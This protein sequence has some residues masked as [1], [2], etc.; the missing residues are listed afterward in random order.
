M[1]EDMIRQQT[2]KPGWVE[3]SKSD[4]RRALRV[5]REMPLS[6]K[7]VVGRFAL[8]LDLPS[9][10]DEKIIVHDFDII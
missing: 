1:G 10:R 8:I 7:S 3:P 9:W 2:L 4:G 5:A 6:Y